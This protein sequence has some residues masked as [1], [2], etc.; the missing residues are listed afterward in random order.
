[1][2]F[3]Y[4]WYSINEARGNLTV[5][6]PW[7]EHTR[8]RSVTLIRYLYENDNVVIMKIIINIR[9]DIL[10]NT[11]INFILQPLI[12]YVQLV[13]L[14]VTWLRLWINGG[15][16]M[17]CH[18]LIGQSKFC[19]LSIEFHCTFSISYKILPYYVYYYCIVIR[20]W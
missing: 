9:Y 4:S 10:I 6:T 14:K 15:G 1:M 8:I 11:S 17:I 12:N 20:L 5:I 13:N 19:F 16:W 3:I 2:N 18:F 7:N